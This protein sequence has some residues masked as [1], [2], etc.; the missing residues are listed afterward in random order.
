MSSRLNKIT[1][2]VA[3]TEV[4][5]RSN[6]ENGKAE[7]DDTQNVKHVCGC[8]LNFPWYLYPRTPFGGYYDDAYFG[9]LGNL[10]MFLDDLEDNLKSLLQIRTL[11]NTLV[12]FTIGA[13]I[14]EVAQN[15]YADY[16]GHYRQL[17]PM[18]LQRAAESE[19]SVVN[20]IVAPILPKTYYNHMIDPHFT[21][22]KEDSG[23]EFS[24]VHSD[25]AHAMWRCKQHPRW[26]TLWFN[27]MMPTI[28]ERN[29]NLTAKM[30]QTHV[31][32]MVADKYRQTQN[33]IQF[34][35]YFY[36]ALTRSVQKIAARN[37][38]SCFNFAVFNV[39][40]PYAALNR[41]A[42]FSEFKDVLWFAKLKHPNQVMLFEWT[43]RKDN[44]IVKNILDGAKM[45][46][47]HDDSTQG[48]LIG[49]GNGGDG[50]GGDGSD[51]LDADSDTSDSDADERLYLEV[52]SYS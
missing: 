1:K 3:D 31:G 6:V 21:R 49:Y 19:I 15:D 25:R 17:I 40:T 36:Q 10:L 12:H 7:N 16:A 43:F 27:T 13:P 26:Y 24:R 18:H 46:D 47:Y 38:V 34:T 50:S 42:M 35:R 48:I 23:L 30:A 9:Q 37:V 8:N 52:V 28:D 44:F 4:D 11:T 51:A 45:I 2:D 41:C 33:D 22:E 39:N 20:I 32:L 14:E 29:Q 5:Y